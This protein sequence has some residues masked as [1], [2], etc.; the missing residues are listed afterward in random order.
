MTAAL[1]AHADMRILWGGDET[2]RTLRRIPIPPFAKEIVFPDRFAFAAFYSEAFLSATE[3]EKQ[4]VIKNLYNDIYW[5]DQLAC[6][7]PKVCVWVGTKEQDAEASAEVYNKL[8][9]LVREKRYTLSLGLALQKETYLY[10]MALELPHMDVQRF[11]NELTVVKLN[12]FDDKCRQHCGSG[13]LYH[14]EVENLSHLGEMIG[15]QDQTLVYYGFEKQILYKFARELN[16]KGLVN[17]VPV[18]QA[19]NFDYLW[20]GYNLLAELTKC[21]QI[22]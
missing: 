22:K 6:S 8:Q 19:L 9:K 4:N 15:A 16:G 3:D 1:S 10:S 21:I 2:I 11:S 20:D 12:Q 13:L 5:Y 14:L 17:I 7:S 18:G